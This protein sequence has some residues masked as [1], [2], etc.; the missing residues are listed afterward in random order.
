MNT[1]YIS[2]PIDVYSGYGSR[3]RDFAKSVIELDKYKVKIIPQRWGSLPEGFIN[4]HPKEWGFLT[5]HITYNKQ[6]D[7]KPDI[8]CQITVPNEFQPIGQYNIGLTA[9]IETTVCAPQWIEGCNKMDLV[10]T[11]SHHS[12]KVF[13]TTKYKV[14]QTQTL[15]LST[16]VEVLIEGANI[17]VYKPIP[18]NDFESENLYEDI[19][20]IDEK[21]AFLFVGHWMKGNIGEDRK[22]VGLLVKSF[23]EVFKNKS[24]K[25]AL[26]L[27]TNEGNPSL[28]G[29]RK[30]LKKIESIRKSTPGKNL[31]KIYVLDGDL[32]DT[33]VNE[34]YNHPK[35]KAMV[36]LTKGEGFGRPLLE[37]SLVNKPIITTG[38]SG[39]TDFLTPDF[40]LLVGGELKPVDESALVENIILKESKWFSPNH[41]HIGNGFLELYNNYKVW[42]DKAKR[43]G[44]ISRTKFDF[45]SMSTQL[46]SYL[47]KYVP[48]FPEEVQ[49]QLPKLNKVE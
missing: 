3:A 33:Q 20:S 8:W 32:N 2:C 27:K 42:K 1:F 14:N 43:Q 35:V 13:E 19:N 5:H 12:K 7:Q 9:G 47:E 40:S 39:H 23:L 48:E 36:S 22:N 46:K 41:S 38:W 49:L 31:P 18:K 15:E 29:R 25:P 16:P 10:L 37:F 44:Y 34:L 28:A 30:I 4:D 17:H 6:L 24:K 45:K 21:F 11:S 26:I